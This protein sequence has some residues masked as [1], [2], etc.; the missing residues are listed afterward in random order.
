MDGDETTYLFSLEDGSDVWVSF[1]EMMGMDAMGRTTL[2]DGS[3]A[4]R[5]RT[6]A[7]QKIK[8]EQYA[9]VRELRKPIVS[10]SLGFAIYDLPQ[11]EAH[12]KLSGCTGIEFKPDPLVPEFLQ[13][14]IN[15]TGE[16]NKYVEARGMHDKNSRN[17]GSAELDAE[18][19]D[20]AK[21]RMLEKFA[22]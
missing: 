16:F 11:Y 22:G 15:S 9:S 18:Q 13:V 10:D 5:K 17:G 3:F 2:A 19:L 4:W 21:S 7:E 6:E 20:K 8:D 1:A 12:R 14:H